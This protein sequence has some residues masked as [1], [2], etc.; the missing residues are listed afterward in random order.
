[1]GVLEKE[2]VIAKANKTKDD[3][4]QLAIYRCVAEYLGFPLDTIDYDQKGENIYDVKFIRNI[5]TD[6]EVTDVEMLIYNY[7]RSYRTECNNKEESDKQLEKQI[8]DF[9]SNIQSLTGIE[10]YLRRLYPKKLTY[11]S[12]RAILKDITKMITLDY[13]L[14]SNYHGPSDFILYKTGENEYKTAD[15]II[16]GC[17][18]RKNSAMTLA[19]NTNSSFAF[20][21]ALKKFESTVGKNNTLT[22]FEKY[23]RDFYK[24][25]SPEDF[26]NIV[27]Y[28][29]KEYNIPYSEN[30]GKSIDQCYDRQRKLINSK[31]YIK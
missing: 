23:M 22:Y 2:T 14:G 12:S 11:N 24:E 21:S 26:H 10:D 16:N 17:L 1:M 3:F 30:Y 6:I 13:L 19:R 28:A 9:K 15:P 18:F 8:K 4:I 25:L 5:P 7:I 31:M 29:F 27:K 20:D